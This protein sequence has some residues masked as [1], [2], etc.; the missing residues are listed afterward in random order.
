M[1]WQ[2]GLHMG[3]MQA[4]VSSDACGAV[5]PASGILLDSM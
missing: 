2:A 3:D 4:Y 5:Q 1:F